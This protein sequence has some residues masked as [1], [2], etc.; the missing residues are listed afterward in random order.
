MLANP[1]SICHTF[2][3]IGLLVSFKT[4]RS[5][6]YDVHLAHFFFIPSTMPMTMALFNFCR[7]RSETQNDRSLI[8]GDIAT[9]RHYA[10]AQI[11]VR[12][13]RSTIS[14]T[15]YYIHLFIYSCSTCVCVIYYTCTYSTRQTEKWRE[16]KERGEKEKLSSVEEKKNRSPLLH[17]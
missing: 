4:F 15:H 7:F 9:I 17:H 2:H 3:R 16:M 10:H 12:K 13:R 5:N 14:N 6:V 8:I 1:N 11:R